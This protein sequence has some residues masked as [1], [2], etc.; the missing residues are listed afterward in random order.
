MS[1]VSGESCR[2][3]CRDLGVTV[4]QTIVCGPPAAA[5]KDHRFVRVSA[6]RKPS[7]HNHRPVPII[8]DAHSGR[9][10]VKISLSQVLR[11]VSR[12]PSLGAPAPM[13][14]PNSRVTAAH[15]SRC[16]QPAEEGV[17]R[18]PHHQAC[19]FQ[20][21]T[22]IF[23]HTSQRCDRKRHRR[24]QRSRQIRSRSRGALALPSI[25]AE[26]RR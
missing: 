8:A 13:N 11:G 18:W 7:S 21:D 25:V 4:P 5:G 10:Q 19:R 12:A 20:Q 2:R 22:T 9:S 14:H 24:A 15:R 6:S 1:S 17:S 23:P 26:T 16:R 3:V